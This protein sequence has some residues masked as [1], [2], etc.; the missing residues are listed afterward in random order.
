MLSLRACRIPSASWPSRLPKFSCLPE[1]RR[2]SQS[3]GRSSNFRKDTEISYRPCPI[4]ESSQVPLASSWSLSLEHPVLLPA[5]KP[6]DSQESRAE[7]LIKALAAQGDRRVEVEFG[8]YDDIPSQNFD[9]IPMPLG[10]YLEWLQE[11]PEGTVRGK[12]L[13]L[14]Q[15]VGREHVGL[16][17]NFHC[18]LNN[19]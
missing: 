7:R 3:T 8:T 18:I 16:I 9:R 14:A 4:P 5:D 10:K 15:W 12:P 6:A 11:T 17:T 1:Y 19:H 13:Y 2:F